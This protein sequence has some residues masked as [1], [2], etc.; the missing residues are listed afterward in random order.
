VPVMQVIDRINRRYP[1]GIAVAM[2]GLGKKT[3][4]PKTESIS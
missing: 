4:T 1:K 3:W 2:T